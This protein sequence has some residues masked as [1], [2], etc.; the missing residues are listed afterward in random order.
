MTNEQSEMITIGR[1]ANAVGVNIDTMRFYEKRGLLP[2][3]NRRPSGYREYDIDTVQRL[4]FILRAKHLGFTLNE[5]TE[6]LSLS[7]GKDMGAV[8]K[9][10]TA[11]LDDVESRIQELKRVRKGLKTVIE[12]CPGHGDPAE[13][14]IVRSLTSDPATDT[15]IET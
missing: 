2:T 4:R 14:P 1:L 8:R 9:A 12:A 15:A 13:C 7:N 11:K 3:P 5:I 6:L 10:A